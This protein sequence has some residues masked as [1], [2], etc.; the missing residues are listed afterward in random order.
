ML[1]E[2]P[3]LWVAAAD[4]VATVWLAFPG[5]PANALDAARI[6]E[7]GRAVDAVAGRADLD[8]VVVRT[9]V[10]AGF[11]GGFTPET[12]AIL[13]TDPDPTAFALAGQRVLARLAGLRAVTVAFVEGPCLGPGLELALACDYRLAVAGPDSWVGFP[14]AA[15]LPPCWGG[16]ARLER[17]GRRATELR[18]GDIVTAKEAVRAG[19]FDDAFS[20]RRGKIE[21]RLFLDRVQARPRKRRVGNLTE[22]LAAERVAFRRAVRELPDRE[23][24]GVPA[25]GPNFAACRK[26]GRVEWDDRGDIAV[27]GSDPALADL[28]VEAALRGRAVVAP[29]AS[30]SLLSHVAGRFAE[31]V[32]RGRA[33]P[34]E[35]DQARKRIETSGDRVT[36]ARFAVADRTGVPALLAAEPALPPACVVAVP[37]GVLAAVRNRAYRPQRVVPDG[38]RLRAEPAGTGLPGIVRARSA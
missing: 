35:A 6:A 30:D 3:N 14:H 37:A 11:G 34:L 33:T 38:D 24:P 9:A 27:F 22:A 16:T 36:A 4:G 25:P 2:S 21:L 28:A 19:V 1:Y 26:F 31:A 23:I 18:R 8:A 7:L 15:T 17:L 12:L 5:P 29:G 13:R 10:P 32:R 20:A